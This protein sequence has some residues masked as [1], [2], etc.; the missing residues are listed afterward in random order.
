MRHHATFSNLGPYAASL[1]L[2]M[3]L[4]HH[5]SKIL[6]QYK[7]AMRAVDHMNHD[8]ELDSATPT[9]SKL[10]P[11]AF[12]DIC[13]I[14]IDFES[15]FPNGSATDVI[16]IPISLE[17]CSPKVRVLTDILLAHHS[18]DFQGIIF[19]EQRQV[20]ACLA[21]VLP[22]IPQLKGIIRSASLVGQG[23][24]LEG[25]SKATGS[26]LGDPVGLFRNG[27]LNLRQP[28]Q[29]LLSFVLF[30]SHFRIQ[31]SL[32]QSLKKV[33][34]SRYGLCVNIVEGL[35]VLT[36]EAYIDMRPCRPLRSAAT[37][38]GIRPIA[39]PGKK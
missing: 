4:Q 6:S 30:M 35:A 22:A 14:I 36:F 1:F 18:P 19:V 15:F 5:L 12:W 27:D 26:N 31:S 9:L 29:P 7:A 25:I 37:Y 21:R 28:L 38:G 17:W 39:W 32:L 33:L 2:F 11:S 24:G 13:D 16:P 34:I 10:I 20:A 8:M 3:E 23:I